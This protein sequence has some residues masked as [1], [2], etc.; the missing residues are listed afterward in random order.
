MATDNLIGDEYFPKSLQPWSLVFPI[1]I[2]LS[3]FSR[4]YHAIGGDYIMYGSLAYADFCSSTLWRKRND[5]YRRA[6]IISG[7]LVLQRALHQ[8]WLKEKWAKALR[9][10]FAPPRRDIINQF[11][12][13]E[14]G[15]TQQKS[16]HRGWTFTDDASRLFFPTPTKLC[17]RFFQSTPMGMGKMAEH[18]SPAT[19]YHL[20]TSFFY[21][22]CFIFCYHTTQTA[23]ELQCLHTGQKTQT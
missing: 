18:A 4:H 15:W 21:T 2:S 11:D 10:R 22:S 20:I 6:A 16:R 7:R 23:Q 14:E 5:E 12:V 19:T 8:I 3:I 17:W 1:L 13:H 9:T